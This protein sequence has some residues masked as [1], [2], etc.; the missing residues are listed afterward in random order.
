[1]NEVHDIRQILAQADWLD[2]RRR[3]ARREVRR[4]TQTE[5][6]QLESLVGRKSLIEIS[7]RLDRRR[8][9]VASKLQS[10]GYTIS[11][12]V[13][14]PVGLSAK[15]VSRRLKVTYD[16]VYRDI[17]AGILPAR[18]DGG[19]D[20]MIYWRDVRA[21]ERRVRRIARRR[22]RVLDRIHEPTI[23]KTE[24][25]ALLNIKETQATRYLMGGVVKGW[26]VPAARSGDCPK[27]RW[28]WVVS[29]KD[30]ER[31][32]RLRAAGRLCLRK[33]AYRTMV[34]REGERIAQLRRDRRLGKR[35]DLGAPHSPVIE[36][37]YTVRQVAAHTGVSDQ[38]IYQHVASGRLPA[39][40]VRIGTRTFL[41]VDP[42]DLPTYLEW[43]QRGQ[44]AT[45]PMVGWKTAKARITRLGYLSMAEAAERFGVSQA[46]LAQ[47]CHDGRLKHRKISGLRAVKP[48]DVEAYLARARTQIGRRPKS[49]TRSNEHG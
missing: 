4:W 5:L 11:I 29:L 49:N 17:C 20:F 13:N 16:Q 22:Q 6:H 15:G 46:A 43:C 1:M 18:K 10:M 35:E 8:S 41:A 28:E 40:R 44:M 26:K 42:A 33:K 7:Q 9:V 30:A 32:K 37:H 48:A 45:G 14:E 38:Q 12:H 24:L 21:Y 3:P 19:K 25:M 2:R 47:A 23:T 27:Q 39:K 31:V 34:R 36:G